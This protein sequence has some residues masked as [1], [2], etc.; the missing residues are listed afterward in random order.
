MAKTFDKA[1]TGFNH[2]IKHNGKMFHVQ[3]EDSG[4]NNPHII[5]HLF[6]GGNIVASQKSSYSDIVG[7]ENLQ[8]RV[9]ALMEV[10]HKE[11]LR[12][13]VRGTHDGSEALVR[14]YAP[15]E[16][17]PPPELDDPA[18]EPTGKHLLPTAPPQLPVRAVPPPRPV[19]AVHEF[20]EGLISERRLDEVIL[21]YL[22]GQ[23]R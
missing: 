11:M 5:T 19:S 17:A 3:T 16:L 10:Q 13:L 14:H 15:G 23:S 6:L 8:H 9:R 21:S 7:N 12:S 20:G 1:V 2:N 22:A 18:S 4:V